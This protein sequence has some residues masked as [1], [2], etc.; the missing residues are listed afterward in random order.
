MKITYLLPFPSGMSLWA[1]LVTCSL[2]S[3]PHSWHQRAGPDSLSR[4]P[5]TT[6][7][8]RLGSKY[9]EYTYT[10]FPFADCQESFRTLVGGSSPGH[11][12]PRPPW[13]GVLGNFDVT[14]VTFGVAGLASISCSDFTWS[15]GSIG[16]YMWPPFSARQRSKVKNVYAP[17][18][19]Y[20]HRWTLLISQAQEPLSFA[21]SHSPTYSIYIRFY[22]FVAIES[23]SMKAIDLSL[24]E[25]CYYLTI[26]SLFHPYST[27]TESKICPQRN[28]KWSRSNYYLATTILSIITSRIICWPG[29]DEWT[30]K[31]NISSDQSKPEWIVYH[32]P[33]SR[34]SCIFSFD[35]Q[36]RLRG[37]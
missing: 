14:M 35:P 3:S 2:P 12:S 11:L 7:W 6:T 31:S 5:I 37:K 24:T 34:R 30:K 36:W 20:I 23:R 16:A 28:F 17:T 32:T 10:L 29:S 18:T 33:P 4:A 19:M 22:T 26:S 15:L 21:F 9:A 27:Y 8:F 13:V 25:L 1:A